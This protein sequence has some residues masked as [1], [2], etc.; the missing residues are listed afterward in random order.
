MRLGAQNADGV[1]RVRRQVLVE[2]LPP[3]GAIQFVELLR[4]RPI[5]RRQLRGDALGRRA[6]AVTDLDMVILKPD[7]GTVR[8]DG[9]S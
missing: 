4:E 7:L 9:A 8:P 5:G 6:G 2:L 1:D 3:N